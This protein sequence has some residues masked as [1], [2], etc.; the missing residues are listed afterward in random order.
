VHLPQVS[1]IVP[2]H[3]ASASLAACLASLRAQDWPRAN[4]EIIYVDDASTDDSPAVARPWADRIVRLKGSPQGPAA[5]RNAGAGQSLGE[6]L[7]FV[8]SDVVAPA[9]TVSGLAQSLMEDAGLDAA[10]GSYDCAPP[11]RTAISQYRNLLHHFVHQTSREEASTFWAGCGAIRKLSFERAGGFDAERYRRPMIE[12]IELGH[13]MNA[14]GMRMKLLRAVQVKHLKRWTLLE[15]L[16][17]DVFARGIPWM[18]LLLTDA[19]GSREIGDLNLKL[20]GVASVL[21]VWSGVVLVLLS[22]FRPLLLIPGLGSFMLA[23]L[24]NLDVY[25]F[26]YKVRGPVFTL[27]ALTPHLMFHFFNGFAVMGAL[28]CWALIDRPLPGLRWIR[29]VLQ[30]SRNRRLGRVLTDASGGKHGCNHKRED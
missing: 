15:V 18:R 6:I 22:F 5:A 25:R 13:R 26:F 3:N 9:P 1:A 30:A 12:D 8:D 16:H 19:K 17:T 7:V 20:S 14:L 21:F 27:K 28:L 10:F 2:G 24:A 23:L 29:N 11:A 4:L